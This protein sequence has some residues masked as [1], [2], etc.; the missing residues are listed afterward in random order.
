M[1]LGYMYLR[2]STQKR[3]DGSKLSHLQIAENVW[4][5]IKK[6]SRV[7]ILYN[8]GRADDEKAVERLRRLAR[9]ILK[10]C[11]PEEL[12]RADPAMQVVDTWPYGDVYVLEQ[13]WRRAGLPD[14]IAN[15]AAG[16]RFGFSVERALFA[17][18]AH[19]ALAPA[20]KRHCWQRWLTDEVHIEGC[21]GLDLQHLYRAMDFLDAHR[22]ALEEGLFYRMADLFNLDVELIFY[23]TTSAHFEIEGEDP[24]GGELARRRGHSKNGRGDAAQVVVGLAVTREGFPVR[25]WVFPGNTV[26][27]STVARV[28]RELQGW[29]LGRCVFVGDAGM[30]SKENLRALARGG[31]R[32]IVCM[33]VHRGG[34]LDTEVLSRRGR[35]REVGPNLRVKEVVLGDG[36]RRERYAVCHNP[37]ETRRRQRHRAEVLAALEK[38]LASLPPKGGSGHSK[39]VCGLRASRRYGRY[40]RLTRGGALRINR[41]GVRSAERL[42]G[43]FVVHTNDD[44]LSAE[45]MALGYRQLQ[46]VEQAWRQ[47]KSGLGLRPVYH[48]EGR[49][50]RAHVALTVLALLLE[51]M[52]EHGVGDTWRN[53][54][55]DLRGI[56]LVKIRGPEGVLWQVTRPRP[57]AAKLLKRLKIEAPKPILKLD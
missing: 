30:V 20:S 38:E 17:M 31:G 32:Y 54:G 41:A 53:I 52:A 25:H 55:H 46:R 13:L 22:E 27:V 44:T 15:L 6:R 28:K 50:I 1:R 40:L 56:K 4:D 7:R 19:R 43:K 24:T 8:C 5:P 14:L 36:E 37:R 42:D 3:A 33:P 45:D 12:V 29:K 47:M 10:R 11:S 23:D 48:R 39:R 34:K 16:R 18:V 35:Y 9:S 51:R 57:H 2:K 21:E 49:R 26:D